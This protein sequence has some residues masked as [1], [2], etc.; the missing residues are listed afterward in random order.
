MYA[1]IRLT[2]ILGLFKKPKLVQF[3]K[4]SQFWKPEIILHW[5]DFNHFFLNLCLEVANLIWILAISQK[6]TK[7]FKYILFRGNMI[8]HYC[9]REY[10]WNTLFPFGIMPIFQWFQMDFATSKQ[11]FRKKWLK[12]LQCRIISAFQNC[13]TFENRKHFGKHFIVL[14]NPTK[15]I[16]FLSI[17]LIRF[18]YQ[19][20]MYYAPLLFI[21]SFCSFKKCSQQPI[22]ILLP[23]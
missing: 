11:M 5:S 14:N 20:C 9:K 10:T 18:I 13:A 22:Y 16:L 7:Y 6:R 8:S 23:I 19:M 2:C 12:S 17:D 4:V 1:H 15:H 21:D 3:S